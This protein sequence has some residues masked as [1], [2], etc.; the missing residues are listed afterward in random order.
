MNDIQSFNNIYKGICI[1]FSV[2]GV[3]YLGVILCSDT[4]LDIKIVSILFILLCISVWIILT[5]VL[6]KTVLKV[7][8]TLNK[9][10]DSIAYD[11]K[12]IVFNLENE[13]LISK[14][15]SKLKNLYNNINA[16]RDKIKKEKESIQTLISDISHQVKTPIAN[17]KLYNSTIIERNISGDKLTEFLKSMD[18]QINKLDFLMDSMIKMS[19]LENGVINLNIDKKNIFETIA[20]ALGSIVLNAEKKNIGISVICDENIEAKHDRKWTSEAMFNI[21]DNAVKYTDFN[22]KIEIKVIPLEIFIK[23]DIIDD[24]KGIREENICKIFNRFYREEDVCNISGIG[25]GLYL[26]KE[27]I[28]KEGGYIKVQSQKGKGSKFSIF[29][30]KS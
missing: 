5:N 23:I 18:T 6:R 12:N 14:F 20:D 21:L 9:Y 25:L 26:S 15:Q 28:S 7:Y 3:L 16:S 29:L 11:E 10:I 27:I 2:A 17:L 4:E 1:I 24:G 13:D 8:S 19:R 22:G 30:L